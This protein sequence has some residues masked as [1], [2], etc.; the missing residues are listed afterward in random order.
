MA[1]SDLARAP[2]G[3]A[4]HSLSGRAATRRRPAGVGT[5]LLFDIS[6]LV[7]Y[8]GEHANP[9]GIQRVQ[10]SIVLSILTNEILPREQCVFLSFNARTR[11]W[12]H[13]AT[14]F[15]ETL[16]QD[17]FLPESQRLVDFPAEEA[18]Y[19]LL[20]GAEDFDGTGILDDGSASVVCLLGAAWVHQDYLHRVLS[21]KRR[22]G[23]R[24]VMTVHDLI[25]IYLRETCDQ[26]T[27]RLFSEFMRR[28]LPHADH[29]LSVS[30]NTAKDIRRYVKT[31][32]VAEPPITVTKNGSSFAEFLP[33]PASLGDLRASDLPERFVLFVATIEGRKN[34]QLMLDIWQRMIADGDD[35]PHLICVGRLGWKSGSFVSTLV[36]TNYLGGRVM[37][38]RDISDADLRLLYDCCL[39]TVYPTLYEGWGLPVGKSLAL[40]RICVSSDRASLPE[41]AGE[42]GVYIDIAD[43]EQSHAVI[44]DLIS[45]AAARGKLEAKIR[46]GYKPVTW[47]SVAET[48]VATC[49]AAPGVAWQ[50]P[51][52]YTAI[53]YSSEISFARLD[54]N[55]DGTGELLLTRIA[56]PRE[57]LLLGDPLDEQAFVR[58]EEARSGGSWAYPEEWGTWACHGDGELALALPPNPSRV[59][60]ALMRLRTSGPVIEQPVSLSANGDVS[61]EGA[62]GPHTR[63]LMLRVR[64][65]V[66]G[67]SGWRLRIRA[68]MTLTRELRNQI[69]AIDAR[70]PT[71]GFER[72]VVVP[73]N[74]LKARLDAL[75]SLLL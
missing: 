71:I 52:P 9:T 29:I 67:P 23:T 25:P 35:P 8:I 22:F 44:R 55:T 16:L 33:Q 62:I 61:W 37:L 41:V 15:L 70:I 57:G 75:Y 13:I 66:T 51:Y 42:F 43:S 59:Y 6:D 36:E 12:V 1:R 20:P 21:L 34:H 40:G 47:H 11:N 14:G 26:D 50:E 54:R 32:A 3:E 4:K 17:L 69:A 30:E 31:L 5:H 24:F 68:Q 19:G 65:K 58:G 74:D 2:I 38:L 46:R 63:N 39:F 48:V 7:Y 45:D 27:V 49:L 60:Y 53:P 72:L 10:S 18:R 56:G 73:E 64:P 28:A